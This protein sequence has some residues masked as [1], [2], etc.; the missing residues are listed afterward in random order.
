[1]QRGSLDDG[2]GRLD[3][4]QFRH[5]RPAR[6]VGD[7]DG[8]MSPNDPIGRGGTVCLRPDLRLKY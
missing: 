8:L 2:A 7:G 5:R 3:L 4:G 6:A 1:V